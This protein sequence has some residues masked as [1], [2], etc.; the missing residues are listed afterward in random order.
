METIENHSEKCHCRYSIWRCVGFG[1]LGVLGFLAIAVIGGALIMWLWN[2]IVSPMFH[3]STIN[4]W[5]AIGLAVLARLLFG[6]CRSGWHHGGKRWRYGMGRG[7]N[8]CRSHSECNCGC[9]TSSYNK[10]ECGKDNCSCNCGKDNDKCS[11]GKDNDKCECGPDQEKWK[12]YDE[13][14]KQ[15]GE[16]AFNDFVKRKNESPDKT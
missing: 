12:F 1:I 16:N 6:G 14:W 9:Q 5:E 3:I 4:F 2:C 7:H 13:Y 11:C 15:E 8:S 10:C